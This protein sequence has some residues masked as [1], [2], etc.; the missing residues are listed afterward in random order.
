[1]AH[2]THTAEGEIPKAQTKEIWAT[3]WILFAITALEFIIAFTMIDPNAKAF[4][5]AF[6]VGLTIVK[7]YFIVANFMHLRHEV[8]GLI[9]AV[10]L[11]CTFIMW[12]IVA[13]L[14]EGGSVFA[15]RF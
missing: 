14:Y 9:W 6:F 11:P 13:M 8:K 2:A 5:I 4:R 1:M 3:F 15:S 12:F 10:I 7:A